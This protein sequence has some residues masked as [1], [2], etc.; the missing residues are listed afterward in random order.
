MIITAVEPVNKSRY[1]IYIDEQFAFVLYKGELSRYKLK[2]GM[3][4]E[5]GFVELLKSEVLLKRAKSRALHILETAP[6]TEAQLREKLLGDYPED[7]ADA[8]VSYAK[9]FGYINDKEYIRSFALARKNQKS[10]A[11]IKM[12]LSQKGLGREAVSEVLEE[13]YEEE[14]ELVA[15]QKILTKRHFDPEGDPKEKQKIFAYLARKG[16]KWDDILAATQDFVV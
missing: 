16:F 5:E 12:L 15:I 10:K 11:E 4:I 9:S 2:E 1:R 7:L 8:A 3:E 6:R 13:V 14:S